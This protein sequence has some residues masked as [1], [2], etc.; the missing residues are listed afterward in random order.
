VIFPP[1]LKTRQVVA[2][3]GA[4]ARSPGLGLKLPWPRPIFPVHFFL[5]FFF[6]DFFLWVQ[7]VFP[8]RFQVSRMCIRPSGAGATYGH[9][10]RGEWPERPAGSEPVSPTSSGGSVD[11]GE[12]VASS[13]PLTT[14]WRA[15]DDQRSR[16]VGCQHGRHHGDRQHNL[17]WVA[18]I[19]S[20]G[21][22]S[23]NRKIYA[24]RC[25][26]GVTFSTVRSRRGPS[27]L[28]AR[29][30]AARTANF[31][32]FHPASRQAVEQA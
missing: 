15:S 18:A 25:T 17:P 3:G 23:R 14:S 29:D 12:C 10:T 1:L 20:T 13:R 11:V 8:W 22:R 4:V 19:T 24:A 16:L 6:F 32:A 28:F 7:H 31:L 27:R 30:T 21:C 5:C 9:L 26:C 2:L